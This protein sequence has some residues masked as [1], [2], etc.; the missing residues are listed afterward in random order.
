MRKKAFNKTIHVDVDRG[1]QSRGEFF[2]A[3]CV[4]YIVLC[5]LYELIIRLRLLSCRDS[6]LPPITCPLVCPYFDKSIPWFIMPSII[7]Q[8]VHSI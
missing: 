1:L 7:N 6:L 2:I 4:I 5:H 3:V 8:E